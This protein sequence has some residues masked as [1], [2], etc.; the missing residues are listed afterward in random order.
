ME[1]ERILAQKKVEVAV[2]ATKAKIEMAKAEEVR[3][4]A[5]GE[6]IAK[7]KTEEGG[8]LAADIEAKTDAAEE[9]RLAAEI[10]ATEKAKSGKH[11][12]NNKSDF[13]PS[14]RN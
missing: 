2:Q 11:R 3:L 4:A 12:S 1:K 5:E 6:A 10:E 13:T 9:A 8:R 7:A 14:N